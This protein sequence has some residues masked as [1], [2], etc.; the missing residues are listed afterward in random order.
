MVVLRSLSLGL[1][2]MSNTGNLPM[3]YYQQALDYIDMCNSGVLSASEMDDATRRQ[4]KAEFQLQATRSGTGRSTAPPDRTP[5]IRVTKDEP[6]I[7]EVP[8]VPT[9]PS[10]VRDMRC[11]G[12]SFQRVP[13]VD[14]RIFARRPETSGGKQSTGF[15]LSD[16]PPVI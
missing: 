8:M 16:L 7:R 11:A 10:G 15:S 12:Y 13:K 14:Q 9:L 6:V 3:W 1:Y 5:G 2:K 4:R